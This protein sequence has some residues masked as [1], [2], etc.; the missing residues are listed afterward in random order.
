MELKNVSDNILLCFESLNGSCQKFAY[1]LSVRIP[2]YLFFG[3]TVFLTVLGNLL[4]IITIVH[5]KQLHSPTNHLVLSLAVADLL[6]GLLL[7]PTC[8]IRSVETC[9]YLGDFYCKIHSSFDVTLCNASILNLSFIAIDRYYAVCHP[10]RY[11]ATITPSVAAAMVAVSWSVPSALGFGMVLLELN[12]MGFEDFYYSN[13]YC[14]GGCVL[15]QGGLSGSL[16]SILSFYVPGIIMLSIYLKIYL[17]A[18]RQAR[19]IHDRSGPSSS[20]GKQAAIN[21]MERKATRTLAII[22]GVFLMLWLPFFV[23]NIT[24]PFI[25]YSVPSVVFDFVVWVGYFNSTVNPIVYAL[26]YS[27]FRSAFRIILSGKIFQPDS[28]RTNLFAE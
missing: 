19:A 4:V 10:L 20:S 2:L 13:V 21:K 3:A 22:M 18:Q 11:Q 12:I 15:F 23:C 26:F 28:S 25:G 1:P 9:W 7:M 16:S 14:K 24:D 8:T 17:I 5:F 6:V 27:W